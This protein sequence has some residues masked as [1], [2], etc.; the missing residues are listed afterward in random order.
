MFIGD[1]CMHV[2]MCVCMHVCMCVCMHVYMCVYVCVHACVYVCVHVC[3]HACVYG[4]VCVYVCVHA[5]V[6]VCVRVYVCVCMCVCMYVYVCVCVFVCKQRAIISHSL[7]VNF[8]I[9]LLMHIVAMKFYYILY[10]L[11]ALYLSIMNQHIS[12][13]AIYI[14]DPR[15]LAI[16]HKGINVQRTIYAF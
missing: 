10:H 1:V 9:I 15:P 2:C 8:S 7:S 4:H 3:V 6:Y 12:L 11:I 16:S 13:C 5:C 14:T